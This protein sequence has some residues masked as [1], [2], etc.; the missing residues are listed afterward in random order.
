VDVQGIQVAVGR[1]VGGRGVNVRVTVGVAVS[2][3]VGV[4]GV[5]VGAV[6]VRLAIS[7]CTAWVLIRFT[8][9]VGA[10]FSVD[11]IVAGAALDTISVGTAVETGNAVFELQAP[12]RAT[13]M[14]IA[15]NLYNISLLF[16]SILQFLIFD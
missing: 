2:V 12:R 7:V 15:R 1:A 14:M 16:I 10:V 13:T 9:T 6:K 4:T 11:T 3:L 8:S 5:A